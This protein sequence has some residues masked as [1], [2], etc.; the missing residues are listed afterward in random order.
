MR[1]RLKYD[2]LAGRHMELQQEYEAL[3]KD[4]KNQQRAARVARNVGPKVSDGGANPPPFI[5]RRTEEN[6]GT[7]KPHGRCFCDHLNVLVAEC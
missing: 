7:G 6:R 4:A 1:Q 2:S 5:P 3:L